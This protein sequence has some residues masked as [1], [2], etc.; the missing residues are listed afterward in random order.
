VLGG[1]VIYWLGAVLADDLLQPLISIF[2]AQ[3]TYDATLQ[4]LRDD[5]FAT[6]FMIG[7]TPFPF[8]LGVAAAGAAGFSVLLFT[9]AVAASRSIRFL[10][11]AIL[12]MI[13]GQS[14]EKLL[15]KYDVEIFIGGLLL[16]AG[17]ATYL[18][19]FS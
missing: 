15:K 19:F 16:F 6:L 3:E 4:K 9:I 1:L 17:F 10:V 5:G 14:A 7:V 11:I 13:V 18:L 8:Q 2:G 12:V